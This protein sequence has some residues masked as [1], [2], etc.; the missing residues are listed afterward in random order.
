MPAPAD[1]LKFGTLIGNVAVKAP[2]APGAAPGAAPDELPGFSPGSV[3]TVSETITP[4]QMVAGKVP[5]T[6]ATAARGATALTAPDLE[7]PGTVNAPLP[8][9]RYYV[10]VGTNRRNRRGAFSPPLGVPLIDPFAA[11]GALR[12]DYAETAVTLEWDPIARPDDIF[13]PSPAYNVYEVDDPRPRPWKD[14]L[15]RALR[16]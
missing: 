10:A 13:A 8:L 12:A 16:R 14:L 6:R 7:T 11:P 15:W 9:M 5:I 1:F 4:E 2:A 3:A